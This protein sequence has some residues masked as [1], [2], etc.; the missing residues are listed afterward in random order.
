[1][2]KQLILLVMMMLPLVASADE[3][4]TC[5]EN[6]TYNFVDATHTLTVLGK[7][8]MNIYHIYP[9]FDSLEWRM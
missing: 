8:N 5:G 7:G 3:N 1:M 9:Q 6:I 2:K 4:G